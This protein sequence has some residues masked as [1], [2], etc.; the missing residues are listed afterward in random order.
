[1]PPS[2]IRTRGMEMV[3]DGFDTPSVPRCRSST[4]G[5]RSAAQFRPGTGRS[6]GPLDAVT[7]PLASYVAIADRRQRAPFQ[8]PWAGILLHDSQGVLGILL[9]LVFVEQRHD[10]ADHVAYG[11]VAELLGDRHQP[12]P[13]EAS[14]NARR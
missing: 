7:A 12:A 6:R 3:C 8:K 14:G 11:V 2:R 13:P 1:M 5:G 4:L 10:L 9:G